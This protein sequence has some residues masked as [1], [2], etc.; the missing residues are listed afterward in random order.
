M[1][2]AQRIEALKQEAGERILILDGAMG[3]MIQRYKLDEAGYRGERFK[4][5]A[6][7]LKGNND[8]LVL[9]QPK[10]IGEIHNAYLEA[11]A[12]IVETNTFNAQAIS[13]AD[14]GLADIAYEMNVAAAKLAREAADAWTKKT[15]H[16]PRF[17]AGAIGP[18]NR[19]ASISP[20]VNNPGFRNV[21]FDDLVDAYATQTRGLIDGG[22]DIILI[23]TV[24]DTLNAKAA[25]FAVE[26]VFDDT[27]VTLPIMISGTITDLSGRNLSGQTPEAFWYS[28]Q[29]LEP[30]S[31]GLNC[32]FGAEQLRPSVDEMAQVAGTYVSVY[33]NAGL[34][35]EMGEYDESPEY[36]AGVLEEWARDGLI[37]IVGGCCGTTPDHI[38]AI[39]AA[40]S[41]YKP[42]K[43][44]EVAHALRLS[45]LEPFVH[46]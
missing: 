36:M 37:N 32:S 44:P 40:V 11:G 16:R 8:L 3:T 5:F 41:K 17:V 35:N 30:F 7:D 10:I 6:R 1:T 9:T 34:P 14:Y 28:M 13:Q 18:T 27:D 31:I 38:R 46:G 43:V 2:R 4:D 39:A 45:G 26:Q 22:V 20:D 23:E 21:G 12:D 15:P 33:P 24:F 29:H 25:G 42:R 19:T